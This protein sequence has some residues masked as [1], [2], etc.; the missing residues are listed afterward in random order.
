MNVGEW[1]GLSGNGRE[2]WGTVVNMVKWGEMGGNCWEWLKIGGNG[3]EWKL[4]MD[5]FCKDIPQ[6]LFGHTIFRTFFVFN[7]RK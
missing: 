1:W 4:S 6:V 3:E 5:G 2:W 7:V